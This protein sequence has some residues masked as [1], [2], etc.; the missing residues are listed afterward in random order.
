MVHTMRVCRPSLE[1]ESQPIL[2]IVCS[3]GLE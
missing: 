1:A 3:D 2:H